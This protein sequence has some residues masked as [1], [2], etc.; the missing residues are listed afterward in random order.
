MPRDPKAI[1]AAIRQ[2]TI[3]TLAAPMVAE[4]E[5]EAAEQARY[6][7]KVRSAKEKVRLTERQRLMVE[8][9]FTDSQFV[10]VDAYKRAGYPR[11]EKNA[12]AE[13]RK[14]QVIAEIKRRADQA[15]K[16]YEVTYDRLVDE[17]AKLAFFNISD[18]M[19]FHPETGEFTGVC[20]DESSIDAL[21][22]LGEI[23]IEPV[24]GHEKPRV[25]VK[26][27]DKMKAIT[28]LMKHAGLS[29]EV[30]QVHHAHEV[31][32]ADRLRK[33]REKMN[34]RLLQELPM[35]AEFEVIEDAKD[36]ADA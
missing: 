6:I 10:K 7:T 18:V 22:A 33:G 11:S 27:Y 12:L 13:F 32:M 3:D 4:A 34:K 19:E 30:K 8:Y 2:K 21:A 1:A 31:T 17:L 28:E 26:P 36:T 15:E 29:R 5:R 23:K 9:Y 20:L 35:E 24:V 25:T 14:P 16:R